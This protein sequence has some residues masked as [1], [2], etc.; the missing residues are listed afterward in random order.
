V[1]RAAR[2]A[3]LMRV[4]AAPDFRSV[5]GICDRQC[6]NGWFDGAVASNTLNKECRKSQ[7]GRSD[8]CTRGGGGLDFPLAQVITR[9][10]QA[11][12]PFIASIGALP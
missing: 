12:L 5:L 10:L 4:P 2:Q 11:K 9:N 7:T 3:A 6:R 1:P 8:G